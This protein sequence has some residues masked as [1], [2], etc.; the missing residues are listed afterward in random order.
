MSLLLLLSPNE[1]CSGLFYPSKVLILLNHDSTEL[2]EFEETLPQR[3]SHE[4]KK[5]ANT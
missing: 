4:K 3:K 1:I 2:E 5:R